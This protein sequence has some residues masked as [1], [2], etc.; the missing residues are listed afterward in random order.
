MAE[1]P[2]D[3]EFLEFII[4]SL[5]SEPDKVEVVRTV[6][7]MGVLLTLKVAQADMGHIIGR[8]GSTARA[9]RSL[10][11]LVGLR[12]N[13]RVNLKIE[14]PEGGTMGKKADYNDSMEES[15]ASDESVVDEDS[16]DKVM[17]DLANI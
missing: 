9:I 1:L 6:D 2:V 3:K 17:E 5:V 8:A 16:A 15:N 7:E 11:R 13:A 14:E 10:V 4:K 12:H